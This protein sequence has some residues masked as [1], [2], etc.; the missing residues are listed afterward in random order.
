MAGSGR[1][2]PKSALAARSA[3]ALFWAAPATSPP[4]SQAP[5][6]QAGKRHVY[7]AAALACVLGLGAAEPEA[8][9]ALLAALAL[10]AAI[11][12]A[13]CSFWPCHRFPAIG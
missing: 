4:G 7:V 3:P 8:W 9:P 12:A 10:A 5:A 1:T 13:T 6:S 11:A 2:C